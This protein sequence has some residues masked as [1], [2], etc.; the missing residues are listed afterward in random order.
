MAMFDVEII[1]CCPCFVSD[2][3][4]AVFLDYNRRNT[5]ATLH[6]DTFEREIPC[7]LPA[8]NI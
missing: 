1:F 7:L 2:I 6:V 5:R 4:R 8:L 3:I